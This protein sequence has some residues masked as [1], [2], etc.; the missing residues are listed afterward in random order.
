MLEEKP[1]I[2]I[3]KD[4]P[5]QDRIHLVETTS[6]EYYLGR[7]KNQ[8]ALAIIL[9]LV[10][11]NS[12]F[13][14]VRFITEVGPERCKQ[15]ASI[16]KEEINIFPMPLGANSGKFGIRYKIE[17]KS[18]SSIYAFP[19][20]T[21]DVLVFDFSKMNSFAYDSSGPLFLECFAPNNENDEI[22]LKD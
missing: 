5:P 22:I 20:S 18:S 6:L 14:S 10:M 13:D 9:F 3:G 7:I 4:Q 15:V 12:G 2:P 17:S 16:A 11:S 21:S 19:G 1:L 8:E